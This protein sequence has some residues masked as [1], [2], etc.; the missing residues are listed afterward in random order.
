MAWQEALGNATLVMVNA[1]SKRIRI[2][3]DKSGCCAALRRSVHAR[4]LGLVGAVGM[5]VSLAAAG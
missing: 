3:N 2:K 1:F 5:D 4:K